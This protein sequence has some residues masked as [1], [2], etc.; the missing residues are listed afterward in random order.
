MR[1]RRTP[2]S[3]HVYRLPGGNEDN[4]LWVH[5]G[6]FEHPGDASHGARTIGSVW[7]LDEHDRV[8]I[9]A[10]ANIELVIIGSAQPP[11]SLAVTHEPLGRELPP[12]GETTGAD[13]GR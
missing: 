12:A 13:D 4:D 1:P 8:A 11:V 6:P 2:S 7:E 9:A 3:N 10:G 5:V